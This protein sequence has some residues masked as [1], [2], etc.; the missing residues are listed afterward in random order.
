MRASVNSIE[1]QQLQVGAKERIQCAEI[2]PRLTGNVKCHAHL[3]PLSMAVE[4]LHL[5][6]VIVTEYGGVS[7]AQR[8]NHQW[9]GDGARGAMQLVVVYGSR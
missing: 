6:I 2:E 1:P 9:H 7:R 4:C 8:S 3:Q 5:P